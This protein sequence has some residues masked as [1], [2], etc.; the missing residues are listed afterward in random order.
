MHFKQ[1]K[2]ILDHVFEGV[3]GKFHT[4][5]K[6]SLIYACNIMI[7]HQKSVYKESRNDDN[8][9]VCGSISADSTGTGVVPPTPTF[10]SPLNW[11]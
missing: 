1:F 6:G 9:D 3:G 4:F 10:W 11:T 2:A 8:R 7:L 5:L